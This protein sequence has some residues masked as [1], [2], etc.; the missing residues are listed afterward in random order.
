MTDIGRKLQ[1]AR[2]EKGIQLEDIAA[3]TRINV[4]YLR[5]LELGKFDFLPL[6]YVIAFAKTYAGLVGID[7]E[8]LVKEL[9]Q[10]A[11]IPSKHEPE[12]KAM[13]PKARALKAEAVAHVQLQSQV[14]SRNDNLAREVVK[15]SASIP[16]LKEITLGLGIVL[17]MALLL[18]LVAR[19]PDKPGTAKRTTR[20][21]S[22]QEAANQVQEIP[23]SE[24]ARQAEQKAASLPESSGSPTAAVSSFSLEARIAE[25]VWLNVAV[26]D[27]AATDAIYRPGS[28]RSWTAKEKIR[29]SVGNAGGVSLM[30]DGKDLGK[31]GQPGQV[32]E[33]VITRDG[34]D[35][36][37]RRARRRPISP[38]DTTGT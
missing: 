13:A 38:T 35:K 1:Q 24:M 2:T 14:Q 36:Q 21:P 10:P 12:P 3:R 11:P 17:V 27:S 22:S 19:S 8:E 32:A 25:Q 4:A 33:L 23:L 20:I 28:V 37:V 26:D 6:P 29:M 15:P 31:I 16:Y 5:D 34:I 7:G 30:L 18:Y 9:R